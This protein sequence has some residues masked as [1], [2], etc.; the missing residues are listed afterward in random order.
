M[1]ALR[2]SWWHPA[3]SAVMCSLDLHAQPPGAGSI[4]RPER[5]SEGGLSS[6]TAP[7][8][9]P[10]PARVSASASIPPS[11]GKQP[12][13]R[14]A[15]ESLAALRRAQSQ[16]EALAEQLVASQQALAALT[17][18]KH[19]DAH[20][21]AHVHADLERSL[22][23]AQERLAK[24][25]VELGR[26]S[27]RLDEYAAASSSAVLRT[28]HLSQA[29]SSEFEQR[30]LKL[31][32]VGREAVR[33]TE[34]RGRAQASALLSRITSATARADKVDELL[35]AER[36]NTEAVRQQGA[37]RS[38]KQAAE[39][40]KLRDKLREHEMERRRRE[41]ELERGRQQTTE[42][43]AK[44]RAKLQAALDAE[45]ERAA[46]LAAALDSARAAVAHGEM[47]LAEREGTVQALLG[48]VTEA[49]DRGAANGALLLARGA[50]E[51]ALHAALADAD[52]GWA[53]VLQDGRRK[54]LAAGSEMAAGAAS[55]RRELESALAEERKAAAES[56]ARLK[57]EIE[58]LK[59]AGSAQVGDLALRATR[60]EQVRLLADTLSPPRGPARPY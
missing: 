44:E 33:A 25:E 51:Q 4:A 14:D 36:A 27:L 28:E 16:A 47:T 11:S 31:E 1:R 50:R 39:I 22:A 57:E 45:A 46:E 12:P 18:E 52:E 29:T 35:A 7:A 55:V 17:E 32:A 41:A 34:A 2:V 59:A 8:P 21:A 19:A 30:M 58:R 60:S 37:E 10:R 5:R 23:L 49:E 43:E 54:M 24:Q 26:L 38:V 48:R 56:A 13:A 3:H 6:L 15:A 53:L 42:R 9:P 20:A 40:Q